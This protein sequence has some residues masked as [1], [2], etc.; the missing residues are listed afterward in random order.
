M[1]YDL[2]VNG[3]ADVDRFA[4]L[5]NKSQRSRDPLSGIVDGVN[6]YFYANYHPIMTSGSVGVYTS[7]SAPLASTEW[8]LDYDSGLITLA[9]A[10]S[11]QPSASYQFA[12]YPEMTIKSILVAGFDEMEG[13]WPRNLYL[14]ETTGSGVVPIVETSPFAYI[15]DSSGSE[16]YNAAGVAFSA[17]R[18]QIGF[19]AKCAQLAFYRVLM[20]E[21]ALSD[22]IWS[23]Y[24]GL[25]VD[26]SMT[27]KNLKLA[28]DA[29]KCSLD[30]ALQLNQLDWYGTSTFFGGSI[31]T[32]YTR[33]FIAHRWWQQKSIA[34]DWRSNTTY[35][36]DRW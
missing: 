23:E 21:H 24:G 30:A 19:F 14:S 17:S 10:P 25:K 22:Y 18:T 29:L 28:Y 15:T 7:G 20:G 6:Q 9:T 4:R 33:D 32:P 12:K 13:M 11:V 31:P 3:I 27:V 5:F 36:G 35:R 34:E 26:K 8:T 1:A 16:P 2:W